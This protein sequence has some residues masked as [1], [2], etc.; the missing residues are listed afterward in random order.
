[1]SEYK[2]CPHC[3]QP[4]LYYRN[5]VPTVDIIIFTPP[6]HILLV[7]RKNPPL[8]WALPGGF[9]DYGESVHTA[10]RREAKEETG[11]DVVLDSLL[12]VYSHPDRDPRQ[13]T[14]STVFVAHAP[15]DRSPLAG[16]DAINVSF[17]PFTDL[18]EMVFDH[19]R[20]LEDF[21]TEKR[22]LGEYS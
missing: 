17:F 12:G 13:H 6:A 21:I 14:M 11:M 16:D 10:A 2:Q 15:A 22:K 4:I 5:P 19:R 20:I 18:P 8:G 1:M 3:G 7:Q 9:V